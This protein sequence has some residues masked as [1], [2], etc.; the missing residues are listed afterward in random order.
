MDTARDLSDRLAL[1]LSRERS[2]LGDFLVALADFDRRQ[3][4]RALGYP[5]LFV[6]LNRHLELSKGASHYRAVAA[7]LV[8]RHPA[9]LDALRE[10]KLCFTVIVELAKVLT[11]EN[12]A[13][14][15]P[16]F[17]HR[18]KTEAKAVSAE[19]RPQPVPERVVVTA[20]PAPVVARAVKV[21]PPTGT[22]R[23]EEVHPDELAL[24]AYPALPPA[25]SSPAAAAPALPP[26]Q[27][28]RSEVIPLTADLR[29]L[30]LTVPKRLLE[31]LDAARDALSH[32]M[33]GASI[34]E[35]LERGLDL[36]LERQAKR[37]GLTD[38]PAK[39]RPCNPGHVPARVRAAVWKRD[40]GRC[41]WKLASGAICGATCRV[42]LDHIVPEGQ[43]GA[44][45]EDNLRCL[46]ER[47][48]KEA[49]RQAFGEEWMLQFCRPGP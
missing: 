15:L 14:V 42:E 46:C 49:A 43:G 4:W 31:K 27:P 29:R 41:Q 2:A 33:P 25:R 6:Y 39:P 48:N 32:A 10:G 40:Q 18:S 3:A 21:A 24:A 44:S 26:P 20:V 35:I 16:R 30:H 5:S 1:L 28:P 22:H 38:R 9:V 47:H 8:Q 36:I 12:E 11:P 34:E 23:A 13:E 7:R 45:T 17:F 19:L 37:R